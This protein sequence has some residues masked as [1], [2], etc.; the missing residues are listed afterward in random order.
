MLPKIGLG[1]P[2][3]TKLHIYLLDTHGVKFLDPR[4][5]MRPTQTT[6]CIYALHL[7][8]YVYMIY[9]G[10]THPDLPLHL[11]IKKKIVKA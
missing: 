10:L 1:P 6:A 5:R 9:R 8:L 2:W 4:T 3:Q 7:Y 11:F